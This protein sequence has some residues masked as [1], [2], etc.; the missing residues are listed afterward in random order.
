MRSPTTNQ[1]RKRLVTLVH[2]GKGKLGLD[3]DEYRDLLEYATGK[4]SAATMNVTELEAVLDAMK[5]LGF[6]AS[7]AGRGR[8]LE[9]RPENI[10]GATPRQ[11]YY[12]KGLWALASRAKSEESLRALILRIAGVDDIRF[13]PKGKASSVILALRD[14]TKKAGYD[15]DG[16]RWGR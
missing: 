3:T 11:V 14:I 9:V 13:I 16:P 1:C 7:G 8:S 5:K 10:G 15:P 4:T 6:V 2:V 12:I